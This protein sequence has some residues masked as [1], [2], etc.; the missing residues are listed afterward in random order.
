MTNALDIEVAQA[1]VEIGVLNRS[2][3]DQAGPDQFTVAVDDTRLRTRCGLLHLKLDDDGL[4][5]QSGAPDCED[6]VAF[7]EQ[8]LAN[9]TGIGSVPVRIAARRVGGGVELGIQR[10]VRGRW[11]ALRQPSNPLLRDGPQDRWRF[12][13]AFDLPAQPPHVSGQ[14]RR[15]ATI[16]TRDGEFVL[17][18]D[19]RT[20]R[21]HCGILNLHILTEHILVDTSDQGCHRSVPLL[22]LCPTSDCDEQQNASY[23][24]ETRSASTLY[25]IELTLS[26]ARAVVNALF[27]DYFP[28][29]NPPSVLFSDE[30]SY[31]H[32]SRTEHEIVLGTNAQNLGLIV[33]ELAHALVDQSGAWDVEHGGAFIALLLDIWERYFPIV[34]ISS[35]HADARRAGIEIA[36]RAPAQ[37]VRDRGTG[38][39]NDLFCGPQP[40]SAELCLSFIGSMTATE[41]S[42]AAGL[43]VGWG[44]SGRLT[45]GTANNDS[46][47]FR[48]YI[49]ADTNIDGSEREAILVV[50][51]QD[52]GLEIDLDWDV[53]RD[54]DWTVRY[55]VNNDGWHSGEWHAG[56]ASWGDA[57]YKRTKLK[58]ADDLVA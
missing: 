5:M 49:R 56:W 13:D 57:E 53:G 20:Y 6:W 47:G 23:W 25:A 41:E 14:L 4:I 30:Q 45:W 19:G 24:W 55:R 54:L 32:W 52:G 28:R 39:L 11:E 16:T 35:A 9:P 26:Q 29:A 43:Y 42:V 17:D 36:S 1:Q 51:C 8:Q 44:R 22:T 15:G 48:S 38:V 58:Q 34:D 40:V 3:S 50:Q 46:G 21:T 10:L 18:I 12:S 37:A 7:G 31:G 33:H 27:A 2:W